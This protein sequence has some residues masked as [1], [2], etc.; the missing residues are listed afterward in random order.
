MPRA[1]TTPTFK[2]STHLVI[3][4]FNDT[5]IIQVLR[6]HKVLER[7][8]IVIEEGL[9]LLPMVELTKEE[10]KAK[11]N[12]NLPKHFLYETKFGSGETI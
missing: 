10:I 4:V 7:K 11:Y 9:F 3:P 8:Y 2:E 1:T 12:V 5:G 6:G